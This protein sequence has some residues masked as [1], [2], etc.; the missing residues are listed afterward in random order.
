MSDV[1]IT[2]TGII[3]AGIPEGSQT[4]AG[5]STSVDDGATWTDI[6]PG[7]LTN[8]QRIVMAI[9]PSNENIVYVWAYTGAGATQTELWKYD[10]STTNWTNLTANMPPPD[11][12]PDLVSGIDVQGSYDMVIKVKPDDANFVVIGGTNLY[13]STDGFSTPVTFFRMDRWICYDNNVSQ[14]A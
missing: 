10:A 14:Y 7:G 5:I 12:N 3:Y 11:P 13:R 2:S 8:Y 6:T 9:A 1:Q 4:D